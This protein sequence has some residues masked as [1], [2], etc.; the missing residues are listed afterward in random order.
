[1][2][3][4]IIRTLL[5]FLV[6][7]LALGP[8]IFVLW[9][10]AAT[11]QGDAPEYTTLRSIDVGTF[12]EYR[13]KLTEQFFKLREYFEVY[14]QLNVGTLQNMA[15]LAD[16]GYK[17]L[18]D[19]LKNKNYL[20]EFLLDV[21]KGVNAPTNDT[22][23]SE[24][25]RSLADYLE[26]V[27]ITSIT[28]SIEAN[29]SSGNAPLTTTFRASVED[30]TGTLILS[31]NY[32]WWRD[33]GGRRIIIGRGPSLNYT[34]QD[35]AKH[36][37][38]LDVTS[39]HKNASG[40]TDVLPFRSRV[41]IDVNE[42]IASVILNVNGDRVDDNEEM[43]FTPGDADYGLLFDATSSTPA[44]GSKFLKTEWDFGN[45]VVKSYSG[46][47]KIERIRYGWE[48]DYTVVLKLTTNENKTVE[49]SFLVSIHDPIAKI[50]S[51]RAD[52]FAGDLFTFTA[53]SS[54]SNQSFTYRW[55]II[56]IE[57]DAI[58]AQS[59][60]AIFTYTFLNKGKYNVRLSVRSP[61]GEV[62]QDTRVVYITSQAPIA[63]FS[64]QIPFSY[65]PNRVKLDASMSFDPDVSD[66]ARLTYTWMVD[67]NKVVLEDPSQN[68]SM[69]FYT[70]NT[71][72]THTITLDVMDP[73]GIMTSKKTDIT[74][75]SL[76]SVKVNAFPRVIQRN[77]F[78]KFVAESP[79]A[80][81]FEWDFG[82]GKTSGWNFD[83][84][85]HTYET[86]GTF[87]AVVTVTDKDGRTNTYQ[88][89]VFVSDSNSP[90]A[91]I[92]PKWNDG[93]NLI[94]D[95]QACAG[96][97]AYIASRIDN[98]NFDG[99]ESINIDGQNQ[100]LEYSW[101]IGQSKF[102]TTSS[103]AYTFDEIGCFPAK[104]SVKSISNGAT[105]AT[106]T[107]IEVRNLTPIVS[108]LDVIIQDPNADPL[109]IDVTAQ[110]AADPDGVIQSYMWY[111]Y[112]DI[113][114]EPQDFRST[115]GNSTTFVLPKVAGNY[116]FVAI[117]KDNNE[118][119]VNSEEVTKSRYFT[120][121]TGDNINTPIID[122]KSNDTSIAVG[123]EVTFTAQVQNILGQDILKDA[124]F[125]WDFDGDGFYDTQTSEPTT[126]YVYRK[127]G[128]FYA[129]VKVKYRGISSTKNITMN[130]SNKLVADFW[131]ISIGNK[132]IFF[133]NSEGQ[134]TERTWDLWDGTKKT[135]TNFTHTYIDGLANHDVKLVISEGT[136]LKEVT[137]TVS[138]NMKNVLKAK[139]EGLNY[140]ISPEL[141]DSATGITL[142][143]PSEK[144]YVYMGEG[145][146]NAK[147]YAIDYD[148]EYDS[149][150]NGGLDDDEDN[151]GTASYV[152]G[153]VV[154]IPFSAFKHQ[155][156]RLFIKDDAGKV[157]ASQ[158]ISLEKTYI[159]EQ[160][161]NPDSIVFEN[162][163]EAEKQKIDALKDF[164]IKLPQQQRVKSLS[165]VQKLQENWTDKTEKTRT[166]VD[167]EKYIAELQLENEAEI[168]DILESLLVE[169]EED[170]SEMEV[171][172]QALINLTPPEITCS[173]TEG[174]CYDTLLKK[175]E[176]INDSEDVEKN[177]ETAKEILEVIA[178]TDL[179]SNEQKID[180]KALLKSLV[181]RGQ[182]EEIPV[183][184]K[185][186]IIEQTDSGGSSLGIMAVL[187]TVGKWLAI[188]I[189]I[190]LGV[191][192]LLY[193]AYLVL[194]KS[195]WQSFSEFISRTTW[196][197]DDTSSAPVSPI[198]DIF[199][200][201]DILE[202]SSIKT[203]AP[204]VL[205]PLKPAAP[206]PTPKT[207]IKGASE[208][209]D[210]L[211]WNFEK[212]QVSVP[213]PEAAK[214]I[215]SKIEVKPEI[216]KEIP[217][218]KAPVSIPAEAKPIGV[219]KQGDIPPVPAETVK[220]QDTNTL[221][222]NIPD[223]LKWSLEIQKEAP[224]I[225]AEVP[226]ETKMQEPLP[227]KSDEVGVPDWLKGSFEEAP[228]T[229]APAKDTPVSDVPSEIKAE[230][231]AIKK[232]SGAKKASEE[233]PAKTPAK[234]STASV[235]KESGA[236]KEASAPLWE[237][238]WDDGMK[239]PDW[240]KVD[241]T[242]DDKS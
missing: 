197:P 167:F 222:E 157:L 15:V 228:V 26:K 173:V 220:M 18:P 78:I 61:S 207:D 143:D 145:N 31:G 115:L 184:E 99:N 23:Y 114:T 17:Y 64:T 144:V 68:G 179:M 131:Y 80:E 109:I 180:F 183:E 205:D 60:D 33:E 28:W 132:V 154:Q 225:S 87:N 4:G 177:K 2:K 174:S 55:E 48:G 129:K 214:N 208:V 20:Q 160:N 242:S 142:T 193:L 206:S 24:I 3:Q 224:V 91:L 113:D 79:Q 170:Q 6:A 21:K 164:L 45:G 141:P 123:E 14:D 192:A 12:N 51:S 86:S 95:P 10:Y 96:K 226:K 147:S 217:E 148:I 219:E 162:V 191:I 171:I 137:K 213:V 223:W 218:L 102:A 76:L 140:F 233:A 118:V 8:N 230:K 40:N 65:E 72:G 124:S 58:I 209:P 232:E 71:L 43:K 181:Y 7:L 59:A 139:T 150:L 200:S 47:P 212:P 185:Q 32:T 190:F 169:G 42:K 201:S 94:F 39:S 237:E 176:M 82:D 227:E 57:K 74:I 151:K 1:M 210:W 231:V 16:T 195:K 13:Y 38:F 146:T 44:S 138:R 90:Y 41:E 19:N 216:K 49:K 182:I 159:E 127:S 100:G 158:D 67:G 202:T 104:L 236:K 46:S 77:G 9:T 186:E 103:T 133:D 54:R 30:P 36:T 53:K 199:Q 88:K 92:T 117:M 215:A 101:K 62:D 25:V 149:D 93:E 234:K 29:P 241:P 188:I 106:E 75:D 203:S 52:G 135:A 84:V 105:H 22:Y 81:V 153:E 163:S 178:Q 130:V 194:G 136:S 69:G 128:E 235:K 125:S 27:D 37:V 11:S 165:F 112:T 166:I 119:R 83:K 238:L 56:D 66:D 134:I 152:T 168:I 98:I 107:N 189:G 161:I 204:P 5:W 121:I 111:Y 198:E 50:D 110:G 240:L 73:D 155:T 70:F 211:K 187:G 156:I 221:E 97:G 116:Y 172:Y 126:T 89:P 63:E 239:I 196:A 85:T 122:L 175:L 120:T 108:A 229:P 34:F 35:E